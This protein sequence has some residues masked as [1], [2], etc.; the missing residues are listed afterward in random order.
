VERV[1]RRRLA[2]VHR[3][4]LAFTEALLSVAEEGRG[5]AAS[6]R[7]RVDRVFRDFPWARRDALAKRQC[8]RTARAIFARAK[9]PAAFLWMV[10]R[11]IR[12]PR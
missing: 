4:T 3:V 8:A 5:A 12:P 2:P 6:A 7:R 10:A 9:S 1:D 11:S